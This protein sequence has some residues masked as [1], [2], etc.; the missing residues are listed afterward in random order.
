MV[1]KS[2]FEVWKHSLFTSRW[3][4]LFCSV[5]ELLIFAADHHVLFPAF[6]CICAKPA[7]LGSVH[8]LIFLWCG[9]AIPHMCTCSRTKQAPTN[10]HQVLNFAFL[11]GASNSL[12]TLE[13]ELWHCSSF[14]FSS[15]LSC[16][17]FIF[18]EIKS[19]YVR[20][21]GR[22]SRTPDCAFIQIQWAASRLALSMSIVLT[23]YFVSYKPV[24]PKL[25]CANVLKAVRE[26]VYLRFFFTK[27]TVVAP[28]AFKYQGLF[29][30]FCISVQFFYCFSTMAIVFLN[31][32][33]YV[34]FV[35]S[36]VF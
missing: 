29:I 27:K 20:V 11:S 9:E 36:L 30:H 31:N 10:E 8:V 28:Y 13:N 14:I 7:I 23:I 32:I 3:H 6:S 17:L 25:W 5:L 21:Q 1:S 18:I 19:E 35:S 15:I 24:V 33:L 4:A 12:R 16:P 2:W 22:Q 26:C 34:A